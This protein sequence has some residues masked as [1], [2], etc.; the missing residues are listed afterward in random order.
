MFEEMKNAMTNYAVTENGAG[1]YRTT[2]NALVDFNFKVSSLRNKSDGEIIALFEPV[3]EENEEI[4]LKYL[5]YLRDVREGLGE[6]HTFRVILNYLLL[7][8]AV[9]PMILN[10][11]SEYGRWDDIIYIYEHNISAS[12][13]YCI[14]RT[15]KNQLNHDII[16]CMNGRSISLMAKWLPSVNASKNTRKIA[17]RLCND[18]GFAEKEYRKKLSLLRSHLDVTEVKM[19]ANDWDEIK[20]EAVP[21]KANLLYKDAFEKHDAERRQEYLNKLSKGETK[22]NASTVYPYEI[23]HNYRY[24]GKTDTTYEEMWKALPNTISNPN[25]KTIVVA[26]GSGSMQSSISKSTSAEAWDVAA[27]LAIYFAEKCEGEFKNRYITFSSRP[28]LVDFG[29]TTS[30][31]DK[32]LIAKQHS[33]VSNTNIAAVF[34]LILTTAI[35]NKMTQSDIPNNILIIS[36]M[37]FDAGSECYGQTLFESIQQKYSDYGYKM[38][39]L[40]FWNVC[41]RSG[42]IPVIQNELGVNLVSGFSVNTFDMILSG[43]TDAFKCIAKKLL[44]ERYEAIDKSYI[45]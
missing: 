7:K 16:D 43:E 40:V 22:I 11:I 20:Y 42:A 17:L 23:V 14:I 27:S 26:D 6:R 15:I 29:D 24:N 35:R 10:M 38:P 45:V 2:G 32:I 30:L 28:Q 37:E 21:S 9:R 18:L 36:D 5:F 39:R 34:E 44:S 33:E 1:A 13:R 8:N 41:S 4:A 31:L 25:N 3:W 12:V 19:S